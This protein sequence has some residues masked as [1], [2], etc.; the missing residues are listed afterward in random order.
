MRR[1]LPLAALNTC[2]VIV[3]PGVVL[4]TVVHTSSPLLV[5]AYAVAAVATSNALAVA[6]AAVWKRRRRSRDVVFADLLLWGWLRRCWT[7]R[8]L[9]QARALYDS[10]RKAG[11]S[12]S[13]E[14]LT[15]LSRLLE[16][17]D[18]YT[19][20][21]GQRVARHAACIARAMHL[22]AVEVAKIQTAATVHDVGKLYTPREILNNSG[23]LND[24][25][26]AIVK[27]HASWG[28][29][30]LAGVGDPEIAAMV[31]HHHE[32]MDGRGYPGGLAGGDIPLGARIIAVADT[33][34]AITSTRAYRR[35]V[36]QKKA[37]DVLAEEAGS[38]LDPAV[39]A[40]FLSVYSSRRSV[41]WIALASAVPARLLAGVNAASPIVATGGS[42]ILAVVGAAGLLGAVPHSH[43]T[44]SHRSTRPG[45]ALI[46]AVRPG[47]ITP[48]TGYRPGHPELSPGAHARRHLHSVGP[49]SVR[50]SPAKGPAT[51]TPATR[52]PAASQQV[53][54][55]PDVH[56]PPSRSPIP[57]VPPSPPQPPGSPT[58]PILPVGQTPPV[59]PQPPASVPVT[60]PSIP[61]VTPP[62]V[63]V[64]PHVSSSAPQIPGVG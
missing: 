52:V 11:P 23:A 53:R 6:G 41:T 38:Q 59:V 57:V 31:L 58:P 48:A 54:E 17:R 37:L 4:A 8:R 1:Y 44:P 39:V 20:G 10:A 21:H 24:E 34:D 33:F 16:A 29:A 28:A 47:V 50:T 64:P 26:Y 51:S 3:L 63:E 19:Y 9:S 7:E 27:G 12:V 2:L 14:L 62:A 18:S 43:S 22:S 15:G 60:I 32:R 45:A 49:R 42:S 40:A 46:S 35:G 55:A 25:E 13:I 5:V 56:A 36:T 30:M 61:V